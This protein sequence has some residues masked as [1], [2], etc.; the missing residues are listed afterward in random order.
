MTALPKMISTVDYHTAGEPFRIVLGGVQPPRGS[1]ILD[2]RD[3][4]MVRLDDTRAM[5]TL[6]PRGHADMYGCFV[7]EPDDDGADLGLIFFHRD[8][9]S[10]A[11]GHGSIAA[12]VWACTTGYVTPR[13]GDKIV[14]D[15]PSGRVT[16]HLRDEGGHP[17]VRFVNIA[18]YTHA[19][20]VEVPTSS[21]TVRADIAY[22][23]AFYAVV[24]ADRLGMAVSPSDLPRLIELSAE[25]KAEILARHDLT[26]AGDERING[27]YGVIFYD[28]LSSAQ[29]RIEERNV[30][31]FADGQV[32]RS[33][34]GSGTC[35]RLAVLAARDELDATGELVN[36]SI[37]DTTFTGRIAGT[38]SMQGRPAIIPEV[39]GTAYLTGYNTLVV[40]PN[41]DLARGFLLPTTGKG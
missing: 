2:K 10:T 20:D 11:C 37:I 27:L 18:S 5:L 1:T 9:F 17:S 38:T 19:L 28:R 15:V 39:A 41:D 21:G 31:V 32:D 12:A 7:T 33:P 35:A 8:G 22:G 36:R 4:A 3:D 30:T 23:G 13:D 6:E 14:L 34:C 29:G 24:E 40:D 26:N 25:I 16:C